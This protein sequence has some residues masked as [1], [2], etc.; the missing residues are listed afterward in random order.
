MAIKIKEFVARYP[1]LYHATR[2]GGW[3]LIEQIGILS[4]S[5]LLDHF[6]VNG[7]DREDIESKHRAESVEIPDGP[8]S[9]ATIRDQKPISENALRRCLVG[10]SPREWYE[11]LNRKV[12][13]WVSEDRLNRLLAAY[14]DEGHDVLSIDTAKLVGPYST[15][16]RLS[17]INAG[18]AGPAFAKRG[19]D[20]FKSF[21][22]FPEEIWKRRGQKAVAELTIENYVKDVKS[23]LA[24]V[25]CRKQG[26]STQVLW[27][28]DDVD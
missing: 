13:F 14:P 23:F 20:H 24:R 16:I 5:A 19:R 22:E 26:K 8:C 15:E 2:A 12:F 10:M 27:E 9:Q 21:D 3:C 17:H 7:I 11:L 28:P 25:E 18:A 4:T 1:R 6:G